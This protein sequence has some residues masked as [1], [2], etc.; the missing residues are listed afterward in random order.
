MDLHRDAP[1]RF[2]LR[3]LILTDVGGFDRS[4]CLLGIQRGQLRGRLERCGL[5]RRPKLNGSMN[6]TPEEI[7]SGPRRRVD[8]DDFAGL[9]AGARVVGENIVEA[10]ASRAAW[11]APVRI[12]IVHR[13]GRH[14]HTSCQAPTSG[15]S[16][17]SR[18]S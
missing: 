2:A 8:P 16:S 11:P 4:R 6:W 7:W 12:L 17:H 14:S 18:F 15:R 3:W 9:A 13:R 1:P 10:L 5:A